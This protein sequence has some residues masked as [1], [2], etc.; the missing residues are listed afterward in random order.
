MLIAERVRQAKAGLPGPL[1]THEPKRQGNPT[2][3][4]LQ[5]KGEIARER[6]FGDCFGIETASGAAGW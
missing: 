1:L 3:I 5:I 2:A 6:N 4:D